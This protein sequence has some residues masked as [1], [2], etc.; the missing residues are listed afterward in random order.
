MRSSGT[1]KNGMENVKRRTVFGIKSSV[2]IYFLLLISIMGGCG[3][4]LKSV[5]YTPKDIN[6]TFPN[7]KYQLRVQ[8]HFTSSFI[9]QKSVT[10]ADSNLGKFYT[11]VHVGEAA[12]KELI[13]AFKRLFRDVGYTYE[14]ATEPNYDKYDLAFVPHM[15]STSLYLADGN[16]KQDTAIGLRVRSRHE[17]YD[18]M[19]EFSSVHHERSYPYHGSKNLTTPQLQQI[20]KTFVETNLENAL[21]ELIAR[22]AD[23]R[24]LNT[25]PEVLRKE[26]ALEQQKKE[27]ELERRTAPSELV[28]EAQFTD[29]FS[30]IPNKSLDAG[31]EAGI[32]VTITNQGRGVAV[33]SK[34]KA[35]TQYENVDF[36]E[37]IEL[38]PN[39]Q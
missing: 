16:L 4:S 31:E 29:K 23:S 26:L 35:E 18:D 21:Q 22:L 32:V 14:P 6:L 27:I 10:V 5:E 25:D 17:I 15:N 13:R 33:D 12:K 36:P 7:K 9:D 20:A 11:T 24:T 28:L 1:P 39:K 38:L 3:A 2:L 19:Q 8:V 37:V 34:V 30:L